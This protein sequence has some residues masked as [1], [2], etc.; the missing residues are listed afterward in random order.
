MAKKKPAS[1]IANFTPEDVDAAIKGIG[2][3][4]ALIFSEGTISPWGNAIHLSVSP[5]E[6]LAL[7]KQ[8]VRNLVLAGWELKH[9]PSQLV[10]VVKTQAKKGKPTKPR[11]IR[12]RTNARST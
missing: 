3:A 5:D 2:A 8:L 10:L 11:T 12:K 6:H 7:G 9:V 1:V 4:V